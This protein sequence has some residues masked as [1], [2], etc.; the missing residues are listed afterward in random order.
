MDK[1]VGPKPWAPIFKELVK[2]TPPETIINFELF[3]R[4]PQPSWA[5]PEGRVIQIGD[6]AHSFLPASGNGA[7]QAIEDAV[8]LA[9][10]LQLGGRDG[11]PES[12]WAHVRL[13]FIRNACAQKM[14]F[15][16]AELL[17]DTD[18]RVV[19]L[20]PRVAQP[21]LPRWVWSHDP[22][23]YAIE[24]YRKVVN[25][26]RLGIPLAEDKSFPPN[27]PPGYEYVPWSIEQI[28]DDATN[29]RPVRLGP[30]NWD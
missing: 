4:N 20:D 1:G 22:E 7:T 18:W 5:S 17:Q 16:N 3:W 10:C 26:I 15:V 13:R 14:G 27:Y 28:M 29:G 30:G 2:L 6:A 9:S 12:V 23:K 24:N 11:V 8:S 25:S 19:K 21:R